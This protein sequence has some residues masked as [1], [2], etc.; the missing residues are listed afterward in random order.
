MLGM[1]VHQ[2]E[3]AVVQQRGML[4]MA[5]EVKLGYGVLYEKGVDCFID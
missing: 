5:L 4:V 1:E 2:E 3:A